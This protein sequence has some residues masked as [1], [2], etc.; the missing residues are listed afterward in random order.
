[1]ATATTTPMMTAVSTP[2]EPEGKGEVEKQAHFNE[3]SDC[4]MYCLKYRMFR[5]V[6]LSQLKYRCAK[7]M[8]PVIHYCPHS[9]KS[10][11]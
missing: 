7:L 2:P 10:L 5:S 11:P 8:N 6:D 4:Y 1:M 3:T 9:S